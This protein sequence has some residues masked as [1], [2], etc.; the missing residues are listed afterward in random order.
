MKLP[1]GLFDKDGLPMQEFFFQLAHR[2]LFH[3][4]FAG[5]F[6]SIVMWIL[7][8][9]EKQASTK[10]NARTMG[11]LDAYTSSFHCNKYP[12]NVPHLNH[13]VLSHGIPQTS[14]TSSLYIASFNTTSLR[15][16]RKR[17]GTSHFTYRCGERKRRNYWYSRR[18]EIWMVY[19]LCDNP[20]VSNWSIQR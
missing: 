11:Q 13:T 16:H 1:M 17:F 10:R 9:N 5:L 7:R 12:P 2:D 19:N 15:I 4:L 6:Q 18:D 20:T 3:D 14:L 8:L